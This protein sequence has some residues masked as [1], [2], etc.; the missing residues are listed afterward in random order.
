MPGEAAQRSLRRNGAKTVF[1]CDQSIDLRKEVKQDL[2]TSKEGRKGTPLKQKR[3]SSMSDKLKRSQLA[4][5]TDYRGMKMI[6]ISNL[7]AQ[8]RKV[9]GEFHIT[10]NTLLR[11]AGSDSGA[12][13]LSPILSGTTA[14][15]FCFGDVAAPAKLLTDFA[16]TSKA[17]KIK[18]ALL[19]GQLV[20][21]D[22]LLAIANLP[23][24]P[25]IQAQLLG[26][27][28][29]P[30]ANLV[31]ILSSPLQGMLG[32]LQARAEQLEKA[33]AA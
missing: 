6:E 22:Q 9:D 16:R 29:G 19:Q 18:A 25:V 11:I 32:V 3:V 1:V 21:G 26:A 2:A 28:Q 7:R 31:G 24:R 8:L 17:L 30:C 5:V 27:L 10:K 12:T 33:S 13:A 15:A 14:I 23:A 4:V 20:G